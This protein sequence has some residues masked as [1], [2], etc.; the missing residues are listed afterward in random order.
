MTDTNEKNR[1]T[2][3]KK[4][5]TD[6]ATQEEHTAE[7]R[8][9]EMPR[10][11]HKDSTFCLLF[12]EPARA[13]ELYNA[14][15][16]ENLPPDT[17]LTYT[18][19]ANAL[20]IDRNNDLGFVIQK[21]H[22][23]MSE[24]QSTINWNIP[25]RCLGYVSR[26]LENLAG[27]EGLYGSKLVKFPV[28]EFY[29]FYVGNETWNTKTLKLSDSFQAPPKENSLELV[30]K[31]INLNYNVNNEDNEILQRSP[32][33]LGYSKLLYYIKT[34]AKENGGD[35]KSAID[36]S[37]KQCME[38]GLIEDFLR[39][40]SREVTGMLFNEITVEEFAEIRAREAYED[41]E[42]YGFT[43]GEQSGFTKGEQSGFTKGEKSGFT[44]GEKAGERIGLAKGRSE[45]AA[46]KQQEI[47]RNLMRLGLDLAQIRQATGLTAE[48]IEKL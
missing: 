21:R 27:K 33:L 46:Q 23:V 7:P 36:I 8:I 18:T 41:G 40:H 17:E 4:Q 37:V 31:F 10:R 29:L 45:G 35:L 1:D 9:G 26:S 38:E 22:L 11:N 5:N 28:P 3:Q 2:T 42:K 15:T 43:K 34:A 20:Y 6:T 48:E 16:G 25:M 30:V 24:C 19:L 32:S 44:K 14:V 39:K 12:S 47:A 13:I